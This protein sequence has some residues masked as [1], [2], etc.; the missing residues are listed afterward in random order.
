MREETGE[1]GGGE[2]KE[3]R[4][5]AIKLIRTSGEKLDGRMVER[6]ERGV[7]KVSR[8]FSSSAALSL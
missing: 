4:R 3:I 8:S 7:L 6:R 5:E 1:G 2:T